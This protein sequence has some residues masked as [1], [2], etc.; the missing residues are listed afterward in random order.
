MSIC[1]LSGPLLSLLY[2]VVQHKN[3]II[4]HHKTSIITIVSE[5]WFDWLTIF[6]IICSKVFFYKDLSSIEFTCDLQ[7]NW[8]AS[9]VRSELSRPQKNLKQ[10]V[11][12]KM[13]TSNSIALREKFKGSNL[14][15][16]AKIKINWQKLHYFQLLCSHILVQAKH[17]FVQ[18]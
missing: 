5:N 2:Q 4:F 14:A 15:L 18:F 10:S 16:G 12:Q 1:P 7:N 3:K 8:N 9:V 6:S 17:L 11:E 13:H